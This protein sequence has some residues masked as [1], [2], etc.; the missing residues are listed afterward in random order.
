MQESGPK[1]IVNLPEIEPSVKIKRGIKV[2]SG[3]VFGAVSNT[4]GT[5]VLLEKENGEREVKLLREVVSASSPLW[6]KI[7]KIAKGKPS[8]RLDNIR[9]PGFYSYNREPGTGENI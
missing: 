2:E 1:P 4:S 3:K 5:W 8:S 6:T 9:P 7:E